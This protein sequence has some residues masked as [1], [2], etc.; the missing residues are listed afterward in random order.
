MR[1]LDYYVGGL[2]LRLIKNLEGAAEVGSDGLTL[3]ELVESPHGRIVDKT[4][5]LYHFALRL[6]NRRDLGLLLKRLI[7]LQLPVAGVADHGV[8]EAV[9]LQDP[10]GNGI[11]IYRDRPQE[12]W[13]EQ[14]GELEMMTDPLDVDGL[15]AEAGVASGSPGDHPLTAL[16]GHVHLHVSDL[17]AAERFYGDVLGFELRQRYGVSAAFFAAGGYHHHIGLNTWAGVGAPP[18]PEDALGLKWYSIWLPNEGALEPVIRRLRGAGIKIK[19][20]DQAY[21]VRDPSRNRLRLTIAEL[22]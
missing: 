12:E 21:F 7:E 9:Y 13:P 18:P 22:A 6:D 11:E 15:L 14:D 3:V 8:S 4:T 19:E 20:E 5:G 2:G 17:P 10:D 1:A 16:M